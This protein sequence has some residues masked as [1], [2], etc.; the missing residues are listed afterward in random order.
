MPS[1]AQR[2]AVETGWL[3]NLA[4]DGNLSTILRTLS[5]SSCVSTF[6][7]AFCGTERKGLVACSRRGGASSR[8][9]WFSCQALS[10]P[11]RRSPP[12]FGCWRKRL[13]HNSNRSRCQNR[14]VWGR[15]AQNVAAIALCSNLSASLLCRFRSL[16][17]R[18]R[19]LR[20][21]S[22]VRLA[23]RTVGTRPL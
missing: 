19:D 8:S 4:T 11:A 12:R 1:P 15:T 7:L 23:S 18:R 9:N 13:A 20:R 10:S 22:R 14:A 5:T 16:W 21:S 17:F 2:C 6:L 3:R